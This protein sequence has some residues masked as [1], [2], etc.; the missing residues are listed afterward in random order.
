VKNYD[1]FAALAQN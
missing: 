1:I